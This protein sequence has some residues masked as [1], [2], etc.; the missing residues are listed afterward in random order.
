MSVRKRVWVTR[1]GEQKE[2][3]I[4]DFTDGNGKR[5]IKTFAQKKKADAY[6]AKVKV[7]I[8]AGTHVALD[9]DMTVAKMAEKWIKGVEADGAERTTIRQ[10]RQHANLHIV[11]RIGTLKLAKLTRGHV[12][13]FRDGLL[14][15]DKALSRPMARKVFTSFKSMLRVMH[16]SHLADNVKINGTK[17]DKHE[18]EI[19]VDI[20]EPAE[21][22]R[23]IE[24]AADNPR[25]CTFLKVAALTGLR[26]SE[27]LGLRWRNVDLKAG[28]L[29]VRQRVDRYGNFGPPKTSSSRR[30]VPLG[31]DLVHALK[32]WKLACPK[33]GELGLVFPTGT[34]AVEDYHNLM[35]SLNP[36]MKVA[37]VVNKKGEPKYALHGLPPFLR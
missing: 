6:A 8:N 9:S 30:T 26:S 17:R 14:A 29:H 4:A 13:H 1:G 32:Q 12:E 24:A 22:K 11:P 3:W 37:G 25:L 23:L 16:C 34:G 2:A 27:L 35:R 20:P 33:E 18:L 19:G 7:D 21:V 5:Q 36:M 28:E 15:G 31:D 10:Y